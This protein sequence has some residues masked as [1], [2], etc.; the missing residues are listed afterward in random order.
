MR[1]LRFLAL[2]LLVAPAYAGPIDPETAKKIEA[3]GVRWWKA[4]PTNRFEE[5]DPQVREALLKEARR[6]GEMPEGSLKRVRDLFW[7]GRKHWSGLKRVK[8]GSKLVLDTPYGEAWAYVS[9]AGKN[10]GLILGLHGGGEGA[11]SASKGSWRGKGCM[12]INPQAVVLDGDAWNTVH[13]E[14]FCLSLI[15]IAKAL[16]EVNPD[17]VYAMGFSMGGTGSWFMAGRHPDLLAGAAPCAGVLMARPKSQVQTPE[18]VQALQHGIVPNV[19]NLP[20]DYFAGMVDRNC[21]PGTY[22]YVW[23]E[24]K[25]LRRDDPGGYQKIRFRA[26]EGLAHSF[27]PGEPHALTKR[28]LQHERD[29]FPRKIVWETA[30]NPFPLPKERDK[31]GR[32]IKR[33]FYWVHHADPQ[34]TMTLVATRDGN[35]FEIDLMGAELK[36]LSILLNPSMIDVQKE[37][38]VRADGAEVYRGKPTPD[39]ATVLETLDARLDRTLTFDRRVRLGE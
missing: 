2:L 8:R 34:D 5:W 29:S 31:T 39:Y 24:L 30:L 19:R 23:E 10:K 9:S 16:H 4:R 11:G 27:A 36:D 38:V 33:W 22:L 17:K 15:E 28:L 25:Q 14:K 13:G 18:E 12:S 6:L 3:L 20:M 32:F 37:V 1:L 35:T 26:V 7:K 21:R